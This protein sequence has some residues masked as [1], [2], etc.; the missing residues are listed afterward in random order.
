M[1]Y[2]FN[3]KKRGLSDFKTGLDITTTE[4][5]SKNLNSQKKEKIQIDNNFLFSFLEEKNKKKKN[6]KFFKNFSE[7]KIV[8]LLPDF[9]LKENNIEFNDIIKNFIS[10]IKNKKKK[11]NFEIFG[12]ENLIF[13]FFKNKIFISK[14]SKIKKNFLEKKI[15][16]KE[17]KK[18]I[19]KIDFCQKG[20]NFEILLITFFDFTKKIFFLNNNNEIFDT[21]FEIKKKIKF[22]F[23]SKFSNSLFIIDENN[24]L[25]FLYINLD[26]KILK[27]I[28]VE[29]KECKLKKIKNYTFSKFSKIRNFLKN[30]KISE[31]EEFIFKEFS[32]FLII[33]K[34]KIFQKNS[35]FQN[36]EEIIYIYEF[37]NKREIKFLQKFS[38]FEI[39]KKNEIILEKILKKKNFDFSQILDFEFSIKKKKILLLLK[40][41]LE[42]Q[43]NI[44][45]QTITKIIKFKFFEI[46]KI[47]LKFLKYLDFE[48]ILILENNN[49]LYILN[50]SDIFSYV[51]D[52]FFFKKNSS[53]IEI[54]EISENFFFIEKIEN[55]NL[56]LNK[57]NKFLIFD[58]NFFK[59][60]QI[61]TKFDFIFNFFFFEF[62]FENFL[63]NF[64]YK[65]FFD[66]IDIIG[67]N[68]F[69]ENLTKILFCNYENY[70]EINEEF[71]NLVLIPKYLK[72]TKIQKI[73]NF[74]KK[75]N[76]FDIQKSILKFYNLFRLIREKKNLENFSKKNFFEKK[77]ILKNNFS[78]CDKIILNFI[79][80]KIKIFK[81]QKFFIL[82]FDEIFPNRLIEINIKNFCEIFHNFFLNLKKYNEIL[83]KDE[84]F[85]KKNFLFYNKI[86]NFMKFQIF[87][88][89]ENLFSDE[90]ISFVNK[91]RN[92]FD[93]FFFFFYSEK[94]F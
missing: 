68:E 35:K 27:F 23:F 61:K 22:S 7:K 72:N 6:L 15:I 30:E 51:N 47:S 5:S 26:E 74:E 31:F 37:Q 38:F 50:K 75:K 82:F 48:N 32:N 24:N 16:F 80:E 78:K 71:L 67:E 52:D 76:I 14:I 63:E 40:N 45:N 89:N 94:N 33:L 91:I 90:I 13:I 92:L 83:K 64:F 79:N 70:F 87:D 59:I 29:K 84:I 56:F 81:N 4:I 21:N 34:K 8:K 25:K 44:K 93:F 20:K 2:N 41:G 86:K 28:S 58:E 57:K 11:Y 1:E 53:L 12:K 55:E 39:L 19:L 54:G 9:M 66:K 88:F 85:I 43:I 65:E 3:L 69:L 60:F 77:K 18:N 10:E 73:Q 46:P 42:L 62:F 49:F 17:L 36:S